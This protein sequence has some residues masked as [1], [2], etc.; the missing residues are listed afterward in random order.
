MGNQSG[1]RIAPHDFIG[2][3]QSI[4]GRE[5][6]DYFKST[7]RSGLFPLEQL[8]A[9]LGRTLLSVGRGIDDYTSGNRHDRDCRRR[10]VD[11]LRVVVESAFGEK[12]PT[13]FKGGK[14]VVL[15]VFARQKK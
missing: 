15:I 3:F 12:R 7:P 14:G 6:D 2:E 5:V 11:H 10:R 8:S 9:H 4:V 13:E 1:G